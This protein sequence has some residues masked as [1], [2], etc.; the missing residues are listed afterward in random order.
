MLSLSFSRFSGWLYMARKEKPR[1]KDTD[2]VPEGEQEQQ[3]SFSFFFR[4]KKAVSY[5][6][7]SKILVSSAFWVMRRGG[8]VVP[9]FFAWLSWL[10]LGVVGNFHCAYRRIFLGTLYRFSRKS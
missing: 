7:L 1:R 8:R 10:G 2:T 9:S 4:L 6:L 5:F 3:K